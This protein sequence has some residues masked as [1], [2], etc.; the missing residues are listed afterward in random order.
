MVGLDY[1]Q[2]LQQLFNS[3]SYFIAS[4]DLSCFFLPCDELYSKFC[5]IS[6]H[7]RLLFAPHTLLLQLSN[8]WVLLGACDDA[9]DSAQWIEA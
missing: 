7:I 6:T 1:W 8:A 2:N 9:T 5:T 3:G 4:V